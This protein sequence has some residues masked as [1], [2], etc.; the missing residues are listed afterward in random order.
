MM[1]PTIELTR[2]RETYRYMGDEELL[3][4]A[5]TEGLKLTMDAYLL[6]KEELQERNI[7][8][9]IIRK[10]EQA[11]ILQYSLQRKKFE[12]D[13]HKDLFSSSLEYALSEKYKGASRYTIYAGLVER[14]ITDDYAS[15]MVN[16]LD[17][18]ALQL[19]R[20][21]AAEMQT[22]AGIFLLG[23]I[24]LCITVSIQRF[25]IAAAMIIVTGLARL[26]VSWKNK[27][28]CKRIVEALA[29]ESLP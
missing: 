22:G 10:L 28:R 11:I 2:I 12:E 14:G 4:F 9:G 7:G 21:A 5:G 23:I 15:Y 20:Q 17:E 19:Q 1:Y 24:V 13:L 3:S 18:W 27:N 6:L 26:L 8:A 16:K 29:T 25:E